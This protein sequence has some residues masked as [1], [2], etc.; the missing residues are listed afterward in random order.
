M[1]AVQW[2]PCEGRKDCVS[3]SGGIGVV[4]ERD[5]LHWLREVISENWQVAWTNM[6]TNICKGSKQGEAYGSSINPC[7]NN[8]TLIEIN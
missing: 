3:T 6:Y 2:I 8:V 5:D 7:D 4:A 1:S